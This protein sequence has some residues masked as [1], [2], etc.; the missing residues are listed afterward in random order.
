[1]R[2]PHELTR[3]GHDQR[4]PDHVTFSGSTAIRKFSAKRLMEPGWASMTILILQGS[5]IVGARCAEVGPAGV[6]AAEAAHRASYSPVQWYF[7]VDGLA[8]PG[9]LGD[10]SCWWNGTEIWAE[11]ESVATT[12]GV[13]T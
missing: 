10:K 1:M 3:A 6:R 12:Y 11:V 5:E 8:L 7:P 9:L 4:L 13:R 2:K